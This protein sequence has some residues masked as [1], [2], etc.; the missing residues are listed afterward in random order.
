MK[1]IA[2][3]I[4]VNELKAAIKTGFSD[5]PKLIENYHII[6]PA[7][8][9]ECVQHTFDTVITAPGGEY[10]EILKDGSIIG[11]MIIL[12]EPGKLLWSF[13][14]NIQYRKMKI[15]KEWLRLV[16]EVFGNDIYM[17]T[18]Y[19]RNMRAIMFFIKNMFKFSVTNDKI[20]VLWQ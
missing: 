9:D 13:G 12:R 14:I 15:L 5:D 16:K 7:S 8:L 17:V 19:P 2:N 4:N 18:L 20:V 11:F 3:R 6:S 10:Y 1:L